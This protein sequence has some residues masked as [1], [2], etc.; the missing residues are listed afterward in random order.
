ME[1]LHLMRKAYKKIRL[2]FFQARPYKKGIPDYC[3]ENYL[4]CMNLIYRYVGFYTPPSLLDIAYKELDDTYQFYSYVVSRSDEYYYDIFD[5]VGCFKRTCFNEFTITGKLS[6][7]F[8]T[9][10]YHSTMA[11]GKMVFYL[12]R[13]ESPLWTS[14]LNSIT[15][16]LMKFIADIESLYPFPSHDD[17]F[18]V[19][20]ARPSFKPSFDEWILYNALWNDTM[21]ITQKEFVDKFILKSTSLHTDPVMSTILFA[22]EAMG[23]YVNKNCDDYAK[24]LNVIKEPEK[25]GMSDLLI[26]K[27]LSWVF[28]NCILLNSDD[29][30]FNKI[31][32]SDYVE[33]FKLPDD[34]Q[35]KCVD[36]LYEKINQY[37]RIIMG[38]PDTNQRNKIKNDVPSSSIYQFFYRNWF[39][40]G[41]PDIFPNSKCCNY[42]I[43]NQFL[44]AYDLNLKVPFNPDNTTWIK[45]VKKHLV[46]NDPFSYKLYEDYK[47]NYV[48]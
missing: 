31:T 10:Y 1:D 45:S 48:K 3:Y 29:D 7:Y 39:G 21:V 20:Q 18:I 16:M 14:D 33:N 26:N 22:L 6:P 37:Y 43:I 41:K 13:H 24:L 46:D 25:Q 2:H 35:K 47:Q 15:Q 19:I 9:V 30:Y 4:R 8:N 12:H 23:V 5:Q 17:P 28:S 32:D 40:L 42:A 36:V 27:V 44:A 34:I 11:I 38:A